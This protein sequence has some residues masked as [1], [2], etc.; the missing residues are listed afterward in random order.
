VTVVVT[1]ASGFIGG[2]LTRSLLGLS[3]RVVTL[4]RDGEVDV[5]G[6]DVVRGELEDLRACERLINEH[7][8]CAVFHLAAQAMV[9]RAQRDPWA[10]M[11]SNV[12]GTY[13]LLEAFRRHAP[14]GA[15]F[16]MASSDKA[17]GEIRGGRSYHE[18]DPLEGRGPYDCSKSCADLIA[19]SY[20]LEYGLKLG[21]VRAGNVY[22]P[23][24]TD[25]SRIVPSLVAD[26]MANRD[27]T[28]MS[29]GTPVRDYLYITDAIAG[30]LS[31]WRH[32]DSLE[33]GVAGRG[34]LAVNLSGGEPISVEDLAWTAIKVREG[35]ERQRH[36]GHEPKVLRPNILGVRR[37]EISRQ[38]LDCSFA[39][40]ELKWE[41]AV[42]LDTGLRNALLSAYAIRFPYL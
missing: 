38:V 29:D 23:G 22:G 10:T 15:I 21:I 42:D 37:G 1:G 17:Y 8:P 41:P 40:R 3:H 19:Q 35:L 36:P 31:L 12:R 24:D 39:K 11:E 16:V 27:P 13:N 20:A 2:A 7:Q 9:Q 33:A 30:Y 32:L 26:L 5:P 18:D 6:R 4:C 25:S 28:I 34:A 14:Q